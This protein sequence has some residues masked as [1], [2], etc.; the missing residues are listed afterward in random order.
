[1]SMAYKMPR[2]IYINLARCEAPIEHWGWASTV[3][4]FDH[5]NQERALFSLAVPGSLV[6]SRA[7]LFSVWLVFTSIH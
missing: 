2:E 4:G 1:M 5:K 7:F 3:W 6:G